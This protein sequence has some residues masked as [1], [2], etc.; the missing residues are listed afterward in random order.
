M[1]KKKTTHFEMG[2][3]IKSALHKSS[4]RCKLKS[5]WEQP[6]TPPNVGECVGR[7][8]LSQDA[9]G[10]RLEWAGLWKTV[11]HDWLKP[12]TPLQG[13]PMCQS[14][15]PNPNKAPLTGWL[16][17]QKCITSQFWRPEVHRGLETANFSLCLHTS[18]L[19]ACPSVSKSPLFI[20][21]PAML[22]RGPSVC[23]I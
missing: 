21:T 14:P 3:R 8:R 2:E 20:R 11:Q 10:W 7:W 22:D 18:S 23:S 5:Q 17:Q 12:R 15:R 1:S 6:R 9:G 13:T 19:C 4:R 16:K